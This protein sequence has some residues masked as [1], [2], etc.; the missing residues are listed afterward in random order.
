[1]VSN[2]QDLFNYF[3]YYILKADSLEEKTQTYEFFDNVSTNPYQIIINEYIILP[4]FNQLSHSDD[5]LQ[6]KRFTNPTIL[7]NN[8]STPKI[9]IIPNDDYLAVI[10]IIQTSTYE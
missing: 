10:K 1:M 6:V 9:I 7:N 4:F 3:P 2:C 8:Y 5:F